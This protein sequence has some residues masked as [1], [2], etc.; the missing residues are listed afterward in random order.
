[1]YYYTQIDRLLEL[2]DWLETIEREPDSIMESSQCND[3]TTDEKPRP[4]RVCNNRF[5]NHNRGLSL[6]LGNM[7]TGPARR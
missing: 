5:K 3:S 6:N 2:Q 7:R 1:M 4:E